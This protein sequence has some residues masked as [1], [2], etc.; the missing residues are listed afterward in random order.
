M[1]FAL[2]LIELECLVLWII[3]VSIHIDTQFKTQPGTVA[4]NATLGALSIN[5]AKP[6]KLLNGTQNIWASDLSD[7]KI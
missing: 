2:C 6:V 1:F 4:K 5:T 3:Q 7:Q